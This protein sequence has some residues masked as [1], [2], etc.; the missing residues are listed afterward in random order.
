MA[1]V[2]ALGLLLL[3]ATTLYAAGGWH[4]LSGAPQVRASAEGSMALTNSDGEGA[5][6]SLADIAPGSTGAGEVTIGNGG[7]APGT[8][9]LAS[10][11]LSDDP[12]RY[13]GL[14]S[15]RLALRIEDVS[16]GT[17]EEV[18]S[19]GLATMPEL[20]LGTL[21]DGESRTYRFL[22][23]MLDGGA[24]SSPF[25]D[26]NLYQQASTGIGYRWTLT[27]VEGGPP[28]PEPP[29][30]PQPSPPA[31]CI[32]FAATTEEK[33]STEPTDRSMPEVMMTNVIPMPI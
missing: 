18:Y 9:A 3:A 30:V 14:L 29:A 19:G 6:F 22:V 17:A 10:T 11:G 24:P 32:T 33:T 21:A 20:E 8:L 23:T 16:S 28:E 4:P 2:A 7:T 5:I 26:D 27:E 13:G 31:P 1:A 12:G 15:Q 25:V